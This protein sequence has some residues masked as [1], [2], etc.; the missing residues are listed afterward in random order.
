MM[1]QLIHAAASGVWPA[2]A[3]LVAICIAPAAAIAA[4]WWGMAAFIRA[5]CA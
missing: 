1:D 3:V 5:E 2:A 4:F